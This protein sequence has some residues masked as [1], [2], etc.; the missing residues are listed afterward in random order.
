MTSWMRRNATKRVVYAT[1]GL[2]LAAQGA[3]A[4]A[5]GRVSYSNYWGGRVFPPFAIVLGL[6]GIGLAVFNPA[7]L[8][9]SPERRRRR[10]RR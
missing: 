1:L 6:A 9:R 7:F 5:Q 8:K 2:A 3:I 4:L 10:G